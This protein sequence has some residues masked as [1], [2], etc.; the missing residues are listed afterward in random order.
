LNTL[1]IAGP[2]VLEFYEI[3]AITGSVTQAEGEYAL[4][5]W[6]QLKATISS[7]AIMNPNHITGA[8]GKKGLGKMKSVN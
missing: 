2:K 1:I 3:S 4:C 6:Y 7:R 5:R 8:D